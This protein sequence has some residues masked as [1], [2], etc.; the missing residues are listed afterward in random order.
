MNQEELRATLDSLRSEIEGLAAK[1]PRSAE[2]ISQL[3]AGVES[4]LKTSGGYQDR[5]AL[6]ETLPGL[7]EQ[8]EVEHPTLTAILSRIITA[9]SSMGV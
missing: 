8:L 5:A 6:L 2:R 4:H 7:V 3:I 1:D 9:L